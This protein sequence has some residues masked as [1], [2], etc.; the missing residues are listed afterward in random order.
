MARPCYGF[1]AMRRARPSS[2]SLVL[3]AASC[4][5]AP[6]G[7]IAIVTGEETDVFTR[8]PAPV[9]L[10]TEKIASD[11]SRSELGRSAL[12]VDTVDLGE[13]PSTEAGAIAVRGLGPGGEPLV[14]GESLFVQWGALEQTTLELFVQRTGELARMPRGPAAFEP[15][16]ATMLAGRWVLAANGTTTMLYDLLSLRALASAPTLPR[17]A[18]SIATY[19]TAA[20]VID[21]QGATTFDLAT[22]ASTPL[23]PPDEGSFADVAGGARVI[24][25][26]GTQLV[27]G[28]TRPTGGPSGRVLVVDPSGSA[29]FAA[30]ATAREGACA[31]YVE[32]RGLV[33]YGGDAAGAGAEVLAPGASL[34]TALPFPPDA[35]RGC[36]AAALD[37]GHVVIAGGRG[38]TGDEGGGLPA[39]VL[40]LACTTACAPASWPGALPLARAEAYA[41]GADAAFVVGDDASGATR[42]YRASSSELR[43]IALKVPRRGAR[44]VATPT[45]SFV[46]VGGGAGLEQYLE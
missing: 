45:G 21:E 42:A 41:L 11:G 17:P 40:D 28:A 25:P 22:G 31:A 33:V 32:G 9:A 1:G 10:V 35:V 7:A 15:A 19:D 44:L 18:R 39:R 14:R 4:S 6:E 29:S 36:A 27:V 16:I 3:L 38:A 8:A 2:L 26:D 23:D 37:H 43:E 46:V 24:A 12:P 13:L 30:L 20:L 5:S 34:A